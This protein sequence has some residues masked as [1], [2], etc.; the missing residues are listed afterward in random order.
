MASILDLL[1]IPV[2]EQ[3]P[4]QTHLRVCRRQRR[5]FRTSQRLCTAEQLRKFPLRSNSVRLPLTLRTEKKI[6]HQASANGTQLD[7]R[8]G[9]RDRIDVSC[10]CRALG[11]QPSTTQWGSAPVSARLQWAMLSP[12]LISLFDCPSAPATLG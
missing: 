12:G 8:E 9:E 5:H 4:D 3:N 1:S 11:A 7:L 2:L 6:F 10:V